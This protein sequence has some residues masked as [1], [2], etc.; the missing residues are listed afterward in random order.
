MSVYQIDHVTTYF[1]L[2]WPSWHHLITW[3]SIRE[4][5]NDR[6][7]EERQLQKKI[8]M[9]LSVDWLPVRETA[10][11]LR[12][13]DAV[14]FDRSTSNR[15][16]KKLLSSKKIQPPVLIFILTTTTRFFLLPLQPSVSLLWSVKV[17]WSPPTEL[18]NC[19][20]IGSKNGCLVRPAIFAIFDDT[21]NGFLVNQWMVAKVKHLNI[22]GLWT[23]EM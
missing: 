1:F 9:T 22:K 21:H 4:E 5:D 20:R 14:T 3:V 16:Q 19:W 15:E 23:E 10:I 11:P 17:R 2:I 13:G 18:I 7:N 12:E 8:F 6:E